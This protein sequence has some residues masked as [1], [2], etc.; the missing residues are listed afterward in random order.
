MAGC[1][2]FIVAFFTLLAAM[3]RPPAPYEVP[4]GTDIFSVVEGT[5][6]W[7]GRSET[8]KDNPHTI[9]FSPDRAT[10]ILTFVK[11]LEGDTSRDTRYELREVTSSSIRGFITDETRRTN[12]GELV[13]WDLV[14]MSPDS[15]GWHRTDWLPGMYT[16]EV[17]RCP[18][19]ERAIPSTR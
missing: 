13:V 3:V 9:S 1:L 14:L 4:A 16:P 18:G 17:V 2:P 6:D 5:W 11:P 10:M 12:D 19:T 8:C 15:Y 7:A